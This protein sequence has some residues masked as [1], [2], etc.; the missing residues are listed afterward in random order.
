MHRLMFILLFALICNS[1]G[2]TNQYDVYIVNNTGDELEVSF[3]T[4]VDRRGVYED[5]VKI[6][7]KDRVKIVSTRNIE[8]ENPFDGPGS[9][10]CG[11]VLE[12]LN[13]T[14]QDTLINNQK[15]CSADIEV[16]HV[17]IGQG[18][19]VVEYHIEDFQ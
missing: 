19:F 2:T 13:A 14:I 16:I 9:N 10:Q 6:A 7:D 18:E 5:V 1:C 15:W 11:K 8:K 12:Y 4:L 3:K 17:D